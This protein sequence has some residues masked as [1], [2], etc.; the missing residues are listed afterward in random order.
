[1]ILKYTLVAEGTKDEALL[2][3]LQWSIQRHTSVL[4]RGEFA[5]PRGK[6]LSEK[7]KNAIDDT[8][9]DMIFV[10]RDSDREH[11]ENRYREIRTATS[12]GEINIPN[13]C[14]VP[15]RM[16]ESWLMFDES[17]LRQAA[18]NRNGRTPLNLPKISQIEGISNPKSTLHE[19]L[20]IA[21]GRRGRRLEEFNKQLPAAMRRITQIAQ[22]FSPLLSLVAFQNLQEELY[23]TLNDQGWIE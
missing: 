10:H 19:S 8:Q 2:P 4:F 18:G 3:I 6:N 12:S 15:V 22:D 9:C 20:R 13:I 5:Y 11:P 1:M 21:S 16:M 17:V 23:S 7:I 14:V